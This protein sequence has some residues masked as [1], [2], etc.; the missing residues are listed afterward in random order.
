MANLLSKLKIK[1]RWAAGYYNSGKAGSFDSGSFEAS[2]AKVQFGFQPDDINNIILRLNLNNAAFNNVDYFYVDTDLKKLLNL[3]FPIS[4][5]LGRMKVDFGEETWGNNS[6]ESV[7][8]SAS[9]ANINGNDEG[10]QLSGK[11]GKLKPLGYSVAVGNGTAGTGSDTSIAKSFAGK[12]Y[13]NIMDPFYISFSYYNS[14][15]LK[16]SNSELGIG[17][18]V[19]RPTGAVRWTRE[20]WEAD[21][22]YDFRKGKALNPPAFCD[23][24]AFVRLAYGGFGEDISGGAINKRD[25]SFGF[26]EGT[27]NLTKKFYLATRLS[28]IDLDGASTATL[29]GVTANLYRRYSLGA[30][31][32]ISNNTILKLG[33]DWNRSSG[34]GLGDADD[35]LISTIL[36]AQF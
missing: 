12:L 14:G 7:L 32:R 8:P 25:G 21:L 34:P 33:Y 22:R 24:R 20:M 9:A 6:V 31:Y 36:V 28:F 11:I 19:S 35:D 4:S 29:N 13:Y 16:A 27:Y 18:L 23:S 3:N 17:G 5:R 1:G 26:V 10:L 30:G 2:E 15:Q